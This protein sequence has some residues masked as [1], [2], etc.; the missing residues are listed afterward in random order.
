MLF[1]PTFPA[2]STSGSTGSV[3]AIA[4]T[5]SVS[6]RTRPRPERPRAVR[7]ELLDRLHHNDL[8]L[9]AELL[10]DPVV[11]RRTRVSLDWDGAWCLDTG[12]QQHD[13]DGVDVAG[14]PAT[15]AIDVSVRFAA[16]IPGRRCSP[17][18]LTSGC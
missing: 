6:V 3:M 7:P 10:Q 13:R 5:A 17:A 8:R 15:G 4:T 11:R 2:T 14:N 18:G 16:R 9:V 1:V 12:A